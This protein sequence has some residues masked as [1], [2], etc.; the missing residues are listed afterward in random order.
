[1]F[2]L[3]WTFPVTRSWQVPLHDSRERYA[4]GCFFENNR[5]NKEVGSGNKFR[6]SDHTARGIGH[7]LFFTERIVDR[8]HPDSIECR[9]FQRQRYRTAHNGQS[10]C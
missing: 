10:G 5:F 6:I 3:Y 2:E 7:P 4:S 1:M 9:A 8:R